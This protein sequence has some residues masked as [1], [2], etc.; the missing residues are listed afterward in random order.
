M[1]VLLHYLRCGSNKKFALR[2]KMPSYFIAFKVFTGQKRC[3]HI[4][5]NLQLY[6]TIEPLMLL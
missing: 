2:V 4:N 6:F 3:H 1:E 5:Q